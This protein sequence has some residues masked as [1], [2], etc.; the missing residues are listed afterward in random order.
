MHQNMLQGGGLGGFGGF[1]G[2]GDMHGGMP[3]FGGNLLHHQQMQ[4][5]QLLHHQQMQQSENRHSSSMNRS[6]AQHGH[7][8]IGF[9]GMGG[10]NGQSFTSTSSSYSYSSNGGTPVV[11]QT[12]MRAVRNGD[13]VEVQ[14][15]FSD[16]STQREGVSVRRNIG[17]RGREIMRIREGNG[18]EQ[19]VENLYHIETPDAVQQFNEEWRHKRPEGATSVGHSSSQGAQVQAPR[20]GMSSSAQNGLQTNTRAHTHTHA[21]TPSHAPRVTVVEPDDE[22]DEERV[23][24][25]THHSDGRRK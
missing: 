5:N 12:A 20:L 19:K 10:G 25:H 2:F 3:G 22:E 7:D 17:E 13:A 18:E 21:H 14:R 8:M 6:A 16:S 11:K 9:G 4:Q 1:G 15:S 24:E 23:T